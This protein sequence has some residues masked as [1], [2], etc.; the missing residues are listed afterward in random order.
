MRVLSETG[1]RGR[2]LLPML[3]PENSSGSSGTRNQRTFVA[4]RGSCI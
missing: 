4:F 1:V 2:Y 3:H